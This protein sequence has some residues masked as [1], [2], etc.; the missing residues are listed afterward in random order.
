M[1]APVVE[2]PCSLCEGIECRRRSQE[3]AFQPNGKWFN[4][5]GCG[6]GLSVDLDDVGSVAWSVI[7]GETGHGA[8]LQLFDPFDF[9]LEAVADVDGES[10]ILGV[11]HVP[12]GASLEGVGVG[13]DK[14][15]ESVDPGI[16]LPHFSNVVVLPLFDCFEQRL[17]NALQGVGV[18]ISA[19]VENVS[20]RSGRDGVVGE[21]VPRGDGNR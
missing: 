3:Y 16:E 20:G 15:L 4:G 8:L 7:F 21:C 18:E 13:F 19:A 5:L 14:V 10:R 6:A 1:D 2:L 11:E 12:L 9:A 17:G